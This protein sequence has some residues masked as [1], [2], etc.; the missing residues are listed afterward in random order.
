MKGEAINLYPPEVAYS[1]PAEGYHNSKM[2]L[3]RTRVIEGSSYRDCSTACLM[4]VR[5]KD[6]LIHYKV[7]DA[8]RALMV[9]MNQAF[10][11][12]RL[13]GME[14]ADAYNNGVQQVLDHPEMSKFRFILTFESDN[15]PPPDGLIKLLETIYSGPWAGVGGLYWTKGEMGMPMIYGNPADHFPNYRP[16]PP[17]PDE[18]Q[19][20]RGLAMGFTLW[21]LAIFKDKRLG[22]PW[23][24]TVQEHVPW[25]G[26]RS[27]TQDLEWCG[28]AAELG[29]RFVM[30][31]RVR[32]GHV[33]GR[34]SP[35]HP[36]DF[37]W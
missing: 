28:R 1:P 7:S 33:Q 8:F 14:V 30:D 34:D 17:I 23:F 12:I 13:A 9:P 36:A 16:M 18:V 25:Q 2:E 24:K 15:V 32:V 11:A 20:C 31:N 4:P 22:P 26:A 21:D 5:R 6:E 19:E 35:T 10:V 29:Y 27:G 3:S 37:V